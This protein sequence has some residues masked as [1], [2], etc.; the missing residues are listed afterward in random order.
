LT[1]LTIDPSKHQ[2]VSTVGW[3]NRKSIAVAET[4]NFVL[5]FK[6][7]KNTFDDAI[8]SL[9]SQLSEAT[10]TTLPPNDDD[11]EGTARRCPRRRFWIK[12]FLLSGKTTDDDD[13]DDD[14]D[15]GV[16]E[17]EDEEGELED[18]GRKQ[19]S[20]DEDAGVSR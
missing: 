4:T 8:L 19:E 2:H 11:E 18:A 7:S 13:D 5:S 1:E 16:E 3:N 20:E 10:A 9:L 12:R 14:D 17:E 15:D 6:H